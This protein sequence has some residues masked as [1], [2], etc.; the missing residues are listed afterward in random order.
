MYS[1]RRTAFFSQLWIVLEGEIE[2]FLL[3]HPGLVVTRCPE[4]M[5]V[6]VTETLA[7]AGVTLEWPPKKF[8][9]QVAIAGAPGRLRPTR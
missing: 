5:G 2:E 4:A 9:L 8:A 1:P 3:A 7:A 6:N